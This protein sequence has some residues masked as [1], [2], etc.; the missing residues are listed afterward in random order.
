M[1]VPLLNLKMLT[2]LFLFRSNSTYDETDSYPA[3]LDT[4]WRSCGQNLSRLAT[5][6][7][8]KASRNGRR[9]SL[10]GGDPAETRI[11]RSMV[12]ENPR[13]FVVSDLLTL[14]TLA[15]AYYCINKI[16]SILV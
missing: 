16:K 9:H 7:H 11:I 14:V 6:N 3:N 15:G 13:K 4:T 12:A 1:Y 5:T 10:G 2:K 8:R